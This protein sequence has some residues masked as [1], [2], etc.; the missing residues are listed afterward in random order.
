MSALLPHFCFDRSGDGKASAFP[1]WI[2]ATPVETSVKRAKAARGADANSEFHDERSISCPGRHGP[3]SFVLSSIT[4]DDGDVRDRSG[5]RRPGLG[6]HI[7]PLSIQPDLRTPPHL[8]FISPQPVRK[9]AQIP[10]G[11][12]M[13]VAEDTEDGPQMRIGSNET[14]NLPSSSTCEL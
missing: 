9:H 13:A 11:L 4:R 7:T 2:V 10:S 8:G 6:C 12:G 5:T 1:R 14:L 3:G